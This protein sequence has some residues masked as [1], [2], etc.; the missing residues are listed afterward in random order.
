MHGMT[1]A[2]TFA[3][4]ILCMFA[5]FLMALGLV[6]VFV[7]YGPADTACQDTLQSFLALLL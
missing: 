3:I 2:G 1:E 6:M 7:L 4:C 5:G